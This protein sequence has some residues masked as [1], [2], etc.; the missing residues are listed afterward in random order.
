M[1]DINRIEL[2][3]QVGRDA[4]IVTVG[5]TTVARFNLATSEIYKDGNGVTNV[6]TTWHSVTA[7]QGKNM[8]DFKSI[9]KGC[10]VHV[11][12]RLRQSRYTTVDGE[13]RIFYEVLAGIIDIVE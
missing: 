5:D 4:R 11:V 1:E 3:G 10:T 13:D 2:Q 9:T 7:W 8:P 6:E 12:G